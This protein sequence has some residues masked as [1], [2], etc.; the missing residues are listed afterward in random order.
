ML[1]EAAVKAKAKPTTKRTTAASL[2]SSGS[3]T[4]EESEKNLEGT[5]GRGKRGPK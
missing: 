3:S 2:A 4:V 1:F 5:T